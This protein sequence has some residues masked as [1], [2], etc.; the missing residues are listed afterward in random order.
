MVNLIMFLD[1]LNLYIMAGLSQK[2]YNL[3]HN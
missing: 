3:I 1:K 2:E